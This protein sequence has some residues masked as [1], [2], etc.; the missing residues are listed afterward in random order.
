MFQGLFQRRHRLIALADQFIGQR[1]PEM[2]IRQSRRQQDSLRDML[3]YI[4]LQARVSGIQCQ[5]RVEFGIAGRMLQHDLDQRD[6][7]TIGVAR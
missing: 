4:V 1:G 5:P 7:T 3:D 6:G 2:D